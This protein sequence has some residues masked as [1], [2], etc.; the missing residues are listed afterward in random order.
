MAHDRAPALRAAGSWAGAD[1][2]HRWR[3]LLVLG[4]IAGLSAGLA[5]AAVA[6]ARRTVTALPRLIEETRSADAVVFPSQVGAYAPDWTQLAAQPYLTD[7]A[8]WSLNFG[9]VD[10]DPGALLF[11][12]S[13]EVWLDQVDRP[14]LV[15]G[16]L[17]D[18]RADDEV[19]VDEHAGLVVGDT[20]T[21]TP[22]G[23]DQSDLESEPPN[24]P[25]LPLTVVGVIRF[26]SQFLFQSDGFVI[27]SPGVLANHGDRMAPLENAHVRLRDPEADIAALQRDVNDLL[28]PGTP[29]LDF[30]AVERR[31]ATTVT[32]EQ[33]ALLALA[34][35]VGLA[36]LVFVGQA[37]ARSVAVIDDSREPLRA[38]GF[39]R[40]TLTGAALLPHLVVAASA[41]TVAVI[42]ALA[43]SA[44]FPIGFAGRVDPDPGVHADW[45][46]LGPGVA[47]TLA[48]LVSGT[49]IIA[50]LRTGAGVDEGG[51]RPTATTATLRRILPLPVGIGAS[52][53]LDGGRG[54]ARVPARPALVGAI[55][56]VVGL[57]ATFTVDHGLGDA[58]RH[59]ERVGVTWQATT[60]PAP[61]QL[62]P[63]GIDDRFVDQILAQRGVEEAS[64]MRRTVLDVSGTGVPTF[65][66]DPVAGGIDLV[67]VSGR[68][69]TGS[70]EA[71]I[72][73]ATAAQ[74]GLTI[75]DTLKVGPEARSLRVTGMALF[76]PDV[77]AGFTEGLWITPATMADVAPWTENDGGDTEWSVALRWSPGT[78]AEAAVADL[79]Q[80][81]ADGAYDVIPAELPPELTN[82]DNVRSLPVVLAAFLVALA[83]STLAHGLATTVR[84]RRHQ[85]AVL[86][87]LGFT[88]AMTRAVVGSHSTT[89]A[90]V[91]LAL[92]I[93][94]G[95]VAGR[96]GWTWVAGE[97]PLQY[98][99]PVR[100]GLVVILV[101]AGVAL[102]I[103]VAAIPGWWASRMHPAQVL[104]SE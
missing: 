79:S 80:A 27:P 103:V 54:R 89:V 43:A 85:F 8:R 28:A 6:G 7:L 83:V 62:T 34:G 66:L 63:T 96:L 18:P 15:D 24:G 9:A 29:V 38:V 36:G 55:A 39:T 71:A 16:R 22:F 65:A 61:D 75:G 48:L 30:G 86:R 35:L 69:P 90:L 64:V 21:F 50:W 67:A 49:T 53:A 2:R 77:H 14:V 10:G 87:A 41:A 42:A 19:V 37:L 58:L 25:D 93:P 32:V 74:L 52:T 81:L 73:P 12:P 76:P 51:A 20:F 82:L 102:A 13:D 46:V 94:L 68:P 1:L 59:P 11:I 17:F 92:G 45:V 78:D 56:A 99:S 5:M 70:D 26:T 57:A 60:V 104:R 91:G 47:A 97:V 101:P 40:A 72:G 44:R 98:V 84:R 95:L 33:T 88:R 31:V 23:P 100:A 4:I 3:W